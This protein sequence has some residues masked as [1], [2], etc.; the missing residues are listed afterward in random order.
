M[1]KEILDILL[2]SVLGSKD[3]VNKWWQSPNKS[4]NNKT[5]EQQYQ[6]DREKVVIYITSH[7]R[8]DYF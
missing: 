6:E 8:G 2:L 5:P 3:L 4:F 1:R 7:T